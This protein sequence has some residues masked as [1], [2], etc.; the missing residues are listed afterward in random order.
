MPKELSVLLN[1]L[2]S[3]I[4]H[5]SLIKNESLIELI[6]S[7]SKQF[8]TAHTSID[9]HLKDHLLDVKRL[10][11][12]SINLW[13][14][15]VDI[16]LF[17]KRAEGQKMKILA[18]L[19]DTCFHI[20]KVNERWKQDEHWAYLQVTINTLKAWLECGDLEN[21]DPSLIDEMAEFTIKCSSEG[22]NS[23]NYK[24]ILQSY[25]YQSEYVRHFYELPRFYML[26][27]FPQLG[28]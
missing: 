23:N 4:N 10:L 5:S 20:F 14:I 18:M 11:E 27:V 13:N 16:H 3:F 8:E 7:R 2:L 15:T 28:V 17:I 19:K 24:A 9:H 1:E 26:N 22:L 12:L 6:W 21:V 25:I